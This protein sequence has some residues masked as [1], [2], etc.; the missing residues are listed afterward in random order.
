MHARIVDAAIRVLSDEGAL[1]FTTTRVAEEAGISVGSLYQYF[2]NKHALVVAVHDQAVSAGWE[3]LQAILDDPDSGPRDKVLRLT[4]WFF[5]AEDTEVRNY[6]TLY[7]EIG[8]FLRRRAYDA[9]EARSLRR[10]TEFVTASTGSARQARRNA[11]LLMTTIEVMGKELARRSPTPAE[12]S[13]WAKSVATM[14]CDQL[15]L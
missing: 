10:L 6:G 1:E 15:G 2:P 3:Q 9:F 13:W 12:L 5:A 14:L 4:T 7:D 8:V 11:D